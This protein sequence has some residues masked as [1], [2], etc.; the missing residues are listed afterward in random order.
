MK[1]RGRPSL[2]IERHPQRFEIACIWAF[3]GFG[4]GPG[5]PGLFLGASLPARLLDAVG[6]AVGG[7]RAT[8][9]RSRR[10]SSPPANMR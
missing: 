6:L 5:R 1:R 4:L 9:H 8:C 2:S 10:P 3:S 7:G